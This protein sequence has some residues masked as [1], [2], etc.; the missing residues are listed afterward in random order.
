MP[1]VKTEGEQMSLQKVEMKPEGEN[2]SDVLSVKRCIC[3]LL[4]AKAQDM[5]KG[6]DRVND[7][8]TMRAMAELY[9]AIK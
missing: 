7:P 5:L 1:K 3:E 9:I 2:N 6:P 8:N 4:S